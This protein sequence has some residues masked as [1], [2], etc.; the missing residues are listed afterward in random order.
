MQKKKPDNESSGLCENSDESLVRTNGEAGIGLLK[1]G[2]SGSAVR[3]PSVILAVPGDGNGF[4]FDRRKHVSPTDTPHLDLMLFD[5]V[6][7]IKD[8]SK[9]CQNSSLGSKHDFFV[10][11]GISQPCH[12]ELAA[13]TQFQ[14]HGGNFIKVHRTTLQRL[15]VHLCKYKLK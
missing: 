3:L 12:N 7:Q 9:M 13:V 4:C 14:H 2:D 11:V 1:H 8:K 6:L 5:F 10:P 15:R